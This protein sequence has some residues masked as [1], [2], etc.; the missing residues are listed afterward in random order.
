MADCC[1]AINQGRITKIGKKTTMPKADSRINLKNLIVLPGLVDAHVHLRDQKNAYKEDFYSG[2]AAAAAG[3]ITTVIDMPNNDPVTMSVET[4]QRRMELAKDRILVNV[5]FYSEF[6]NEAQEIAKIV[7]AGVVAFKLYLAKQIG[8][9]DVDSDSALLTAF[10]AAKKR[11]V[12]VAVHAEDRSSL[13]RFENQLKQDGSNDI[14]AFLLAHSEKVEVKAV[15]RL[16]E[17]RDK[18]DVHVHLCHISTATSLKRI[19]CE[20]NIN[21]RVCHR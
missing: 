14:T 11:D 1:I 4:L 5:G 13:K 21:E 18:T 3:G 10:N 17:L 2:T 20:K 12:P 19:I 6:P 8:G 15:E 16:I 7:N 9:L